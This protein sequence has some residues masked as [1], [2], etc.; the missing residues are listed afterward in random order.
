MIP[1]KKEILALLGLNGTTYLRE[2]SLVRRQ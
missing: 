2:N 1:Q